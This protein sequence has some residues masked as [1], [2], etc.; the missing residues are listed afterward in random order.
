MAKEKIKAKAK[1][2]KRA[3]KANIGFL[4]LLFL[5]IGIT[6]AITWLIFDRPHYIVWFSNHTFIILGL[7]L[8]FRSQ[9]WVFAEL[10]LGAIPEL[11]WSI[12]FLSRVFTGEHVWGFTSYMFKNG[13][14]DWLHIY[15]FQHL[16]FVPAALYAMHLLGGPKRGAW[17]GSII[18]GAI[19]WKASFM[20]SSEFNLNCVYYKCLFDLPNYQSSWPILILIHILVIYLLVA[21]FWRK[22]ETSKK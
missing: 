16:L 20:F 12:D 4:G 22:K 2:K 9:F 1:K 18:H 13:V 19:M 3:K 5:L 10:C 21:L 17:I 11:T 8:L 14:F 15:S 7:A 6:P